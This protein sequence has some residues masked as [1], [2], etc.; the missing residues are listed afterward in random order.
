ML[1]IKTSLTTKTLFT[2]TSILQKVTATAAAEII[3]HLEE[4]NKIL[5]L[6]LHQLRMEKML[7][8]SCRSNQ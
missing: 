2:V 5:K 7:S 6:K 1:L 8:T 4:E 3:R